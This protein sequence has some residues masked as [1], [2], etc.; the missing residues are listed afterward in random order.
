MSDTEDMEVTEV[1]VHNCGCQH[2]VVTDEDP[3]RVEVTCNFCEAHRKV[4][5]SLGEQKDE[6][7]TVW[8]TTRGNEK[9]TPTF[10]K[11]K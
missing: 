1:I 7:M 8:D 4:N 2:T 6:H 10:S 5:C 3:D 9:A 11:W